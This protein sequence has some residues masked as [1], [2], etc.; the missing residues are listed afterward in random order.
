MTKRCLAAFAAVLSVAMMCACSFP[1]STGPGTGTTTEPALSPVQPRPPHEREIRG[2]QPHSAAIRGMTEATSTDPVRLVGIAQAELRGRLDAFQPGDF[3]ETYRN[4]E[5]LR[6]GA[7]LQ[8]VTLRQTVGGVPIDDSYLR[9][10]V[11]YDEKGAKLVSSSYRLFENV[12][13]DAT[14]AIRHDKA[15]GAAEGTRYSWRR[16]VGLPCRSR[17]RK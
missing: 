17:L 12:P 16:C 5:T 6:G 8:F 2:S 10:G 11:R 4:V 3:V 7:R 14:P 9:I 13:V 15:V 1:D